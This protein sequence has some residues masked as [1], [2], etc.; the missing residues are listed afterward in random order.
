MGG[1]VPAKPSYTESERAR[2]LQISP[3][4]ASSKI[5]E[6][7][8]SGTTV[9]ARLKLFVPLGLRTTPEQVIDEF[10]CNV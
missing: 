3:H 10:S 9:A 7:D 6:A 5:A 1:L 4:E 2:R 8:G